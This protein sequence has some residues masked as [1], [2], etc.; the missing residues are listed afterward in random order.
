MPEVS[1]GGSRPV[2]DMGLVIRRESGWRWPSGV[3]S[4]WSGREAC[5]WS[6]KQKPSHSPGASMKP[7]RGQPGRVK[8][9]LLDTVGRM[10]N[11]RE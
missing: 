5:E 11:W 4:S 1:G 7:E 2:M 6:G 8:Q 9:G 3:L 10:H